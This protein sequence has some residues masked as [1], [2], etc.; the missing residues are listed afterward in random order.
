VATAVLVPVSEYLSTA[1]RPDCD[2]IDGELKERRVG[3][4][5]HTQLQIILGAIF[6]NNRKEWHVV[7]MGDQRVQVLPTRFRVPDLCV[8]RASDPADN[9]VTVPPLLCVEILSKG[10]TLHELQE[11]VDDYIGMGAENVWVVNPWNRTAYYG[12]LRGF[13]QPGDGVLRIAGTP[14]EIQLAE[15]FAE[16]DEV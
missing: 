8:V 12:S 11:R 9:I 15:V 1:Y 7:A 16:L 4:R 5:P 6:R 13:E 3:E 2:Y 10:D 14:I